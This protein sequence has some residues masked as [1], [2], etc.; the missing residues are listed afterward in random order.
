MYRDLVEAPEHYT[1]DGKDWWVQIMHKW[2]GEIDVVNVYDEEGR[3][4]KDFKTEEEALRFIEAV[5]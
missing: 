5:K 3:F 1:I 2:N 4:V